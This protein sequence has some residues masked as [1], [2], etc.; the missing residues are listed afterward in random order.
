MWRLDTDVHCCNECVCKCLCPRAYLQNQPYKLRP[1]L[2][3]VARSFF[4]GV[5]MRYFPLSWS[6]IIFT[7]PYAHT[8]KVHFQSCTCPRRWSYLQSP[9]KKSLKLSPEL[10]QLMWNIAAQYVFSRAK[11][12][13]VLKDRAKSK[14][15][16]LVNICGDE[17][18]INKLQLDYRDSFW[19]P[20]WLGGQSRDSLCLRKGGSQERTIRYEMLF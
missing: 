6:R 12:R 8:H 17:Y 14:S 15:Q 18:K 2:V 9:Q 4:V 13:P 1:I 11:K 3:A 20:R 10:V 5:A 19:V 7:W 16:K